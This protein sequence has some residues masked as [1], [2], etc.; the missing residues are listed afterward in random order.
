MLTR[1]FYLAI[2]GALGTVTRYALSVLVRRFHG[3]TFPLGTAVV[4]ILGCFLVGL[5]W[6][7][8]E[9]RW[10]LSADARTSIF[11]GFFGAFTTFSSLVLEAA[12]LMSSGGWG[13]AIAHLV[14]HNALG[15]AALGAGSMLAELL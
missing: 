5:V 3:S 12:D 9:R 2:A 8:L 14:L 15:L 7:I 1:L 11:V 6:S 10:P 4:N 13:P